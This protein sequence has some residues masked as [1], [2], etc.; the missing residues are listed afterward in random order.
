M[1]RTHRS[2]RTIIPAIGAIF[3]TSRSA[4]A[5]G[6]EAHVAGGLHPDDLLNIAGIVIALAIAYFLISRIRP[7]GSGRVDGRHLVI[8][9][10][11]QV[12]HAGQSLERVPPATFQHDIGSND[13]VPDDA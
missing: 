5:H 9:D 11:E 12:P 4:A 7:E 6:G 13:E 3:P 10:G 1:T 2:W 8:H